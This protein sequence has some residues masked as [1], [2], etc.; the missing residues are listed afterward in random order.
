MKNGEKK[1]FSA[2]SVARTYVALKMRPLLAL[3]I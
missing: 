2:F 3:D 1:V